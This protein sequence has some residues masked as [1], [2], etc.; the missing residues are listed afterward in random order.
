MRARTRGLPI[1]LAGLTGAL[2]GLG[3]VAAEPRQGQSANEEPP[4]ERF[5]KGELIVTFTDSVT[6]CVHHLV[7]SKKL[8]EGQKSP[9]AKTVF[10]RATSDQSDSLD[11]RFEAHQIRSARPL[12]RNELEEEKIVGPKTL[13][14]LKTLHADRQ[15]A[16][17]AKFPQR[18][19]RAPSHAVLPDLSHIYV[20]TFPPELPVET[21][22]ADLKSD[23]HIRS[24]ELNSYYQLQAFPQDPPSDP[25]YSSCNSW[26][27]GCPPDGYDD[28]WGVKQV[29]AN[30]AWP[31]TQGRRSDTT[32]PIVVAVVDT[33][34][35]YTH[36]DLNDNIWTNLA[37]T[38]NGVDDGDANL[39]VDD[40]RG[41][42]F[43]SRNNDT[44]DRYGHGTHIAGTI[45]AEANN[46]EGVIGVA[47]QVQIMSVKVGSDLI[48]T[49]ELVAQGIDYAAITCLNNT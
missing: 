49:S 21:V 17:K 29:K 9:Y 39:E 23:P 44:Q 33:G 35:D 4:A 7:K 41:Y 40:I 36:P 18:A 10:K 16:V 45:A 8:L 48:T 22:A 15:A 42:N 37:E 3:P 14:A 20:V 28:L 31:T 12:F 26:G 2:L 32:Q 1:V 47:P 46:A 30:L 5:V 34:V 11:K 38:V 24:V 25:Y 27:Q 19:A 13:A 6:E 43:V